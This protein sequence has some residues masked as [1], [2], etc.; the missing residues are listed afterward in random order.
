M[1]TVRWGTYGSPVV[2]L[3]DELTGLVNGGVSRPGTAISADGSL[4]CDVEFITSAAFSPTAGAQIDLWLLRSI[5]G[6]NYED[7]SASA[8][9][10]REANV[11]I[12]VRAGVSIVTRAGSPY[13]KL[14]PGTY[15]AIARNRTGAALPAGTIV[16]IATYSEQAS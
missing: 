2:I 5:D 4:F 3:G 12:P 6:T 13:L 9:P 7:G 1:A 11:T 16:R 14:P 8:M 15:K 10:P